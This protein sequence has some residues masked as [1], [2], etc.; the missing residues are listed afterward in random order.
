MGISRYGTSTILDNSNPEYADI[1]GRRG[2]RSITHIS[3]NKFKEI[4]IKDIPGLQIESYIWKSSDKFYKLAYQYYGDPTYWWV[5]AFWNYRPLESDVKLGETIN[6]P[7]QLERI[8]SILEM[9][10]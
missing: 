10:I 9:Q 4:L 7:L 3:F 6:I 5:I 2:V 8:L 1:I